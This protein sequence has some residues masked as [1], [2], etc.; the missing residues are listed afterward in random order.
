MWC[1]LVLSSGFNEKE[2]RRIYHEVNTDGS[3]GVDI[4][5]F[6]VVRA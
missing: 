1:M 5:E 4:D 3:D 6:K 2:A